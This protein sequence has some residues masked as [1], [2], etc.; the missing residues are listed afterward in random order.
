MHINTNPI[1]RQPAV[2]RATGARRHTIETAPAAADSEAPRRLGGRS[3]PATGS[4]LPVATDHP[5][6]DHA[7]GLERAA[8]RLRE[9]ALKHPQA[10]GLQHAL[11]MLQRNQDRH[12]VDTQA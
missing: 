8:D 3:L 6:H 1:A 7:Q 11:D 4:D 10:M 2:W 12:V 9:A 5:R